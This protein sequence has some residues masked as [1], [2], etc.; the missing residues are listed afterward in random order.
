M[1]EDQTQVITQA[2]APDERLA[3][4]VHCLEL[5]DGH[6]LVHRHLVGAE[7]LVIGR[8]AP[9]NIIL[10]DSEVSRAHCRVRLEGETLVVADL[11][12]TNG[13]FIDGERL[14][15]PA[16]LPVGGA[17]RIGHTWLK[18]E[19]RTCLEV[20]QA[21][22]L[23]R[24]L[25][26]AAA[27]VHAL[28]PPPILEGPLRA[29]WIYQPSAKLGGDAFGYGPLGEDL[30]VAYLMDVSGHGASAAMHSVTVMNL[31]RQRLLPAADMADPGHVITALNAM[32]Q[33]ERHAEMYFTMWY[34]AFNPRTRKLAYAT[35][36]QH[37]AFL[38]PPGKAELVPLRTRNGI[39][40]AVPG[41][42]YASDQIDVPAGSQLFLFSDGVFEIVTK[43]G[44]EW[45]LQDFLPLLLEPA[46]AG[47]S[48]C[49]RIFRDVTNVARPGGFDDDFSLVV[50]TFD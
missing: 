50:L 11:G 15:A 25:G 42:T 22:Q 5:S 46:A 16:A 39:I 26:Q 10:A 27:Y 47:L 13:T 41:K 44:Q 1:E 48:T 35:A 2:Q 7:G 12:S 49:Q 14:S 36:G 3:E 19:W 21:D 9:A 6:G 18:H 8:S 34:G 32:F 31:L 30:F 33:M 28:L 24:D 43:D 38:A 29:D 17:I 45:G 20:V 37:A 23:D 40:G 4:R